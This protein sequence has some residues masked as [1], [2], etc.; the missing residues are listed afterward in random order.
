MAWTSLVSAQMRP[1]LLKVKWLLET[2]G[3]LDSFG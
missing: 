2:I 1:G 3:G